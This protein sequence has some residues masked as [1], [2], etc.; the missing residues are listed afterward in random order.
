MIAKDTKPKHNDSK[1]QK[2]LRSRDM[3]KPQKLFENIPQNDESGPFK[4]LLLS[5]PHATSSLD[6]SLDLAPNEEGWKQ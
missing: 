6:E 3:A 5:K 1:L 2:S 4:P